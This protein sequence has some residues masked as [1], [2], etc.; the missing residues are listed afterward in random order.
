MENLAVHAQKELILL[1][2]DDG[3]H[4]N[5]TINWLNGTTPV[6]GVPRITTSGAQNVSTVASLTPPWSV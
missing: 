6:A 3:S 4:P 5:G 1:Y 2:K